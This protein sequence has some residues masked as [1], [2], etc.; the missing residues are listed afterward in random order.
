MPTEKVELEKK[1]LTNTKNLVGELYPVLLDADGKPIDG[2]HRLDENPSWASK[3]LRQIKTEKQRILARLVAHNARRPISFE[4]RQADITALAEEMMKEGTPPEL[5][6]TEITNLGLFTG[7][8]VRLMLGDIFK[9]S[10]KARTPKHS[11]EEVKEMLEVGRSVADKSKFTQE[12][13]GFAQMTCANEGI[14]RGELEISA[15]TPVATEDAAVAAPTPLVL[16]PSFF[17]PLRLHGSM[18]CPHCGGKFEA[19]ESLENLKVEVMNP[20]SFIERLKVEL[21]RLV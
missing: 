21:S 5:I 12:N 17:D 4:E 8:Y 11:P 20:V 10:N 2:L 13:R 1:Y 14:K 7:A 18:I 16:S 3:K 15:D 9:Q 6:S 19:S